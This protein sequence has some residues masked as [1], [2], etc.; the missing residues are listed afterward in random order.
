MTKT[1]KKWQT[2]KNSKTSNEGNY[3]HVHVKQMSVNQE[4]AD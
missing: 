4:N 1:K 3:V 2:W